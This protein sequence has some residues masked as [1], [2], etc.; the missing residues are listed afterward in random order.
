MKGKKV[1]TGDRIDNIIFIGDDIILIEEQ[2]PLHS[3]SE[4]D[5]ETTIIISDGHHLDVTVGMNEGEDVVRWADPLMH[6]KD[7]TQY[8]PKNVRIINAYFKKYYGGLKNASEEL[9]GY[10][11]DFLSGY[12]MLVG[13]SKSGL[14]MYDCAQVVEPS[15]NRRL[16]VMTVS[17]PFAGTV[18]ASRESFRK[19]PKKL[20]SIMNYIHGAICSEHAGDLDILPESEFISNLKPLP[21]Q[22]HH[23]GVINGFD[24]GLKGCSTWTDFGLRLV[25][26]LCK[27]EGDGIVSIE[28]QV[29]FPRTPNI[30]AF[31]TTSHDSAFEKALS[32]FGKYAL[33]NGK[34]L[35]LKLGFCK[36]RITYSF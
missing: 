11:S 31:V 25:D 15:K 16:G 8:F 12:I 4:E 20:A 35:I 33:R 2:R 28:S 34:N 19:Q 36:K 30:P 22:I 7:Y 32:E 23:F 21:E 26:S 27:I 1:N 6:W 5:V 14:M 3:E 9:A 10:I 29:S 18:M 17:A 24:G 13:H